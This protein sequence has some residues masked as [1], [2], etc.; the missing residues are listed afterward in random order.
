MKSQNRR[1]LSL[2]ILVFEGFGIR[3]LDGVIPSPISFWTALLFIINIRQ[4]RRMPVRCWLILFVFFIFYFA[5]NVLKGVQPRF[6]LY[7]GWFSA[8]FVL[9]NYIDGKAKFEEDLFKFTKLCVIY[10]L[11]HFPIQLLAKDWLINVEFSLQM[12]TF[13]YFFYY[14]GVDD[15]PL[16]MCRTTGFCWEPS[17]WNCLLNMHLALTLAL[18]KG[19]KD[20]V[21]SVIA[22]FFVFSSTG[23]ATMIVVFVSYILLYLKKMNFSTILIMLLVAILLVPIALNNIVDKLATGSGA[24]RYGDFFIAGYVIQ[25]SPL[26][27]ADLE[28][29]TSNANAM[30]AKTDNWGQKPEAIHQ[31]DEVGM[32][33]AF[34]ALFVEWG[35]VV[36]LFIFYLMY[37]S[38]LFQNKR[39][40]FV[41]SSTLLVVLMGTPIARTGFFYLFPLSTLLIKKC[42]MGEALQTRK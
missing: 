25:T 20:I 35:V 26:Q 6:F 7:A 15:G 2:F 21:L 5:F 14:G 37:R 1:I 22:I 13:M 34:A 8:F 36:T 11:L 38:P 39:T 3:M 31:Y 32:T 4:I 19:R 18:N 10:S 16:G 9:S 30:E 41:V 33:N 40:T 24:T 23:F 28:N 17:C 42:K 29:I 27:G 12:K